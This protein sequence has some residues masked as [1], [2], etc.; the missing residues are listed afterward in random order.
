MPALIERKK[1]TPEEYLALEDE[2]EFRSEYENGAIVAM[3]SGSFNHVQIT[4]NVTR[5][6]GNQ[7]SGKCSV[8]PTD[9]KVWVEKRGKFYYPD[10]TIVCGEQ[11]FHQS[12]TDTITNPNILVEVLSKSTE[13]KDRTEKFWSYQLIDSF[14]EYVLV[15]Q[16]KAAIEQFVRQADGS[17][18]YLAV[19]GEE[20]VLRLMTVE[21]ELNLKEVYQSIDFET[22]ENL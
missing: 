13:A 21:A 6:L 5:A 12:R 16:D 22:E 1:Y 15:S 14:Q 18:R 9:M 19:I 20:S 7:L 3:A 2:A 4:S 17:W 10:I 8:L 11:Q